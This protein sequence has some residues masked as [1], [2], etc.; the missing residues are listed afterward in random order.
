MDR[1]LSRVVRDELQP[2]QEVIEA[3]L[4]EANCAFTLSVLQ[5]I[6]VSG[7][8]FALSGAQRYAAT[9]GSAAVG[10]VFS[11]VHWR[12]AR[13]RVRNEPLAY[14]ANLRQRFHEE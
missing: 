14:L 9:I 2:A 8:V 4:R 10:L 1:E 5:V 12:L 6:A 13:Q 11:V 3:R 7:I